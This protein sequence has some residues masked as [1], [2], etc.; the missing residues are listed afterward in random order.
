[1]VS[2][3]N[4]WDLDGTLVDSSHR[5]R[6]RFDENGVE[7]IDLPF[8]RAHSTPDHIKRDKALPPALLYKKQLTRP[9]CYVIIAT[10]RVMGKADF[11]WVEQ[12]LGS[13][14]K[15]V[16]RQEGDTTRGG[17]LK[18]KALKR[19][20]NLRQFRGARWIVHEDNRD[21]LDYLVQVLNAEGRYYP[22][23]QGH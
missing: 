17:P 6:T 3:I 23:N 12:H 18:A 11:N 7:K 9:S 1:M 19:L 14:N 5:Y 16:Y 20:Q 8:W 13:P 21:Y 15:I 10:A 2:E 4:V 22:S